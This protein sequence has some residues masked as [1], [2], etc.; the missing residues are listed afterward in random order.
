MDYRIGFAGAQ[1]SGKTTLAR[2]MAEATG[3]VFV[4][5]GVGAFL[6][7]IGVDL[8]ADLPLRERLSAQLEVAKHIRQ[9]TDVQCGFF[10]DRT[11]L[12]VMV[13]T[14]DMVGRNND[15]QTVKMFKCIETVCSQTLFENF[16][17][18]VLLRPGV[19]LSHE[20]FKRTQRGSLD[21]TY[22]RRIDSLMMG[23]Y[24]RYRHDERRHFMNLSVMPSTV[25]DIDDRAYK[26]AQHLNIVFGRQ[27]KETATVH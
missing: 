1:G 25:L 23:E 27:I 18:V 4:E 15:E 9:V 10:A 5:T 22:V 26:V 3:A 24:L 14:I 13:Y 20:D 6:K 16:N 17:A 7:S 12:D 2:R 19:L 8:G 21:P 11:P